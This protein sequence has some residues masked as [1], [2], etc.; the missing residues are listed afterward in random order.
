M[1]GHPIRPELPAA[2]VR[3]RGLA[4]WWRLVVGWLLLVS[5][6]VIAP[7][8]VPIGLVMMAVGLGLLASESHTVRRGLQAVR[9]R[10]PGFCARLNAVKPRVPGF[11]ARV[12][13]DTDPTGRAA[14]AEAAERRPLD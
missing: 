10:F 8:P 7:T 1:T 6:G 11:V 13:E 4:R 9:R 3:R 12:I 2:A 14:R 5:G